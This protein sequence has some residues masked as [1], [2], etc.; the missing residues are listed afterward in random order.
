MDKSSCDTRPFHGVCALMRRRVRGPALCALLIVLC[1]GGRFASPA[2]CQGV[3]A[4]NRAHAIE[5]AIVGKW[6]A[7]VGNVKLT[8]VLDGAGGFV[9]NDR[10]GDY[11]IQGDALKLRAG[12]GEQDYTIDLTA[13]ILTVSGGDLTQP[14]KFTRQPEV[15]G[16][17]RQLFHFSSKSA[18]LRLHRILI[19]VGIVLASRL[20]IV[21]LRA[22]SH[23]IVF[24][25]W[26]PLKYIYKRHKNRTMTIHSLVLN[27]LK[28]FIYFT[29]LGFILSEL[30]INYTAY[31]ASLSV[32]G[33]AIGFGSQ[34]LVQDVVTGFFI[35]FEGQFEVG[36]MVEISGQTGIVEEIGLRMT[37]LRNYLG[38]GVVIPNRNIAVVGNYS[39]GAL[40]TRVDVAVADSEAATQAAG[41][42]EKLGAEMKRQFE[43]VILSPL[44]VRGPLSLNT[45]EHF[46]RLE[47]AIWPMQQWVIDQQLVPRIREVL[48]RETVEVPGDR[49]VAF[50]HAPEKRPTPTWRSALGR[51][52][53][54]LRK[55]E[56][57]P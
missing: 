18:Y 38:Q 10:K 33:L 23:F 41:I 2:L 53:G 49:I 48:K 56:A 47:L 29:T 17:V 35:I 16:Y 20:I 43:G 6:V 22:A 11:A 34:G 40:Q 1:I 5:T 37:R 15:S 9:M 31:I 21:L 50:Y 26:G 25:E 45:G 55:G 12:T 24:S 8:L 30:G 39:K 36:D 46:V 7:E 14:M 27:V 57:M 52:K 19:V 54:R 42:L 51:L 44:R 28:Y 32:I 3:M 4:E 13:D